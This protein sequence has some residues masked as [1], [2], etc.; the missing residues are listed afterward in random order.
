MNLP[1]P[2]PTSN[3][4]RYWRSALA[5]EDLMGLSAKDSPVRMSPDTAQAGALDA[6]SVRKIQEK[7]KNHKAKESPSRKSGDLR[8][9][10]TESIPV[11][12]Y[13]KGLG[14]EYRHGKTSGDKTPNSIHYTLFVPA[15]LSTDGR[16]SPRDDSL[17]W[18]G[19]NYLFPRLPTDRDDESVPLIGEVEAFD[20]WLSEKPLEAATWNDLMAWC[21]G[22]WDR[23]TDGRVPDGFVVLPDICMDI[24]ESEKGTGKQI[25]QLYD[26]L[27]AEEK[28]PALFE[29]LCHGK[30][31]PIVVSEGLRRRQMS[32]PRGTMSASYGLANSQANAVAAFTGM[33]T[34]DLLAVNGP[35]GT[36]KTTLLQ[37]I[38]ASEVVARALE[39]GVPSVIVGVS[40]N[41]QAVTNINRSLNEMFDGNSAADSFPWAHRWV[42]D[43]KTY[44]LYLPADSKVKEAQEDGLAIAKKEWIRGEKKPQWTGFTEKERDSR[45]LMQAQLMWLAGYQDTY[46]AS[47]E[48]VEAGLDTL[49]ND[50]DRV[51]KKI[52]SMQ[53]VIERF[54]EINQWWRDTAG[55]IQPSV[56]VENEG[57]SVQAAQ[58][59]LEEC[60]HYARQLI[61]VRGKVAGA[62]AP[63][64]FGE[65]LAKIIP[66]FH[67]L[68]INGQIERL[69]GL[70]S[71][72][73]LIGKLFEEQI[74]NNTDPQGWIA[75]TKQLL[76][77]AKK[78]KGDA[79]QAVEICR[80]NYEVLEGRLKERGD[81]LAALQNSYKTLLAQASSEFQVDVTGY[82]TQDRPSVADF[83]RV[84]D[85]TLRHKAFQIAVRYWEG[86]WILEVRNLQ[87]A[88]DT[89]KIHGLGREGMEARFRRWC[90]L[91][92]CLVST[93]HSLPKHFQFWG[94]NAVN[95]MLEYIDLLIMD[96]SGQ[97]SP[98]IGAASFSLANRAVVVGDIYQIEP[99]TKISRGTD[100]GNSRQY[101]LQ[102][103]WYD[104]E[105]ASPHLVS[106]P[107]DRTP[108]GS[109][110][111]LAQAAS[112]AVSPG[113][114]QEPG[115]FLSEHRRC[116]SEIV[117]YCN[118]LIYA[119]RLEPL[120][121]MKPGEDPPLPPM[122]WAHV[123]GDA[124][125]RGGSYVNID[126]ARAIVGWI[127]E[128]AMEWQ[129]RYNGAALEDIVAIVTPFRMQA[130]EI[131][132]AL[133]RAGLRSGITVGTVH[134]LQGAQK[135]III[136]SPV[137]NADTAKGLFFDRK[138]NMLNV[139]VSRA[140]D[141]FVVI[142]DMRLFRHGDNAPSSILGK[143]LLADAGNELSNVGGHYHF[144]QELLVQAARISTLD[145]HRQ[146]LR[147]ALTNI[148]AG[149]TVVIASPWITMK[150]IEAD[151]LSALVSAAVKERGANVC[152]IVDG[153][154]SLRDQSHRAADAIDEMKRA[155]AQ[156][157]PVTN[158]HNKTLIIGNSEI[159]EGSFNWLSANRL[160]NDRYVRHDT[161]W[162]I[163]GHAA[164]EAIEAAKQEF[165]KIGAN[166]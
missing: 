56:F 131:E 141:S 62:L 109:V 139:A 73:D 42:P 25:L 23:V 147:G 74:Y 18:I 156:V 47:V 134:R 13:M 142:G 5:D 105:P 7:W 83:D 159:I 28:V 60:N 108:S 63:R 97:V 88:P 11:I 19:R 44:G 150:A 84:L 9:D 106:E 16:I 101:G 103:L 91:T 69:C 76:Q 102:S 163:T 68:A 3:F 67:G 164:P 79:E 151:G 98:H 82:A 160:E 96:E 14:P 87:D 94:N 24:E 137:Y 165:R 125:K 17:P 20:K 155:G 77:Q 130:Q 8:E 149:E 111:R 124:R 6:G 1:S 50:L 110:M 32:M 39:G 2:I 38:I 116:R 161:S 65:W 140:Q 51:V 15:L 72:D 46:S 81:C 148:K 85:V 27:L 57:I 66:L 152:I 132:M 145:G 128:N 52:R 80:K 133:S 86:R 34:G 114:E 35:P 4:L 157:S 112:C 43:A 21:D 126:E 45:Y 54:H 122:A 119:G 64:G 127:S 59:K 92:P 138:P 78:D 166:I 123:R 118:E 153:E 158:M 107:R 33:A 113:T 40:T 36:G 99:V 104:D 10:D 37:S 48:T 55:D 26:A 162:R 31:N 58:K 90:M 135:P 22:L 120:R 61:G 12:L 154:L 144:P 30:K 146:A 100:Y 143:I 129:A 117:A 95:Y 53:E 49:R 115:I 70:A 71:A 136:F 121:Q 93:L 75:R 41:N 89:D 29:R